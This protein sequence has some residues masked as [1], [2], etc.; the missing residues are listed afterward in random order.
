MSG[1]TRTTCKYCSEE[2]CF[3]H[4]RSDLSKDGKHEPGPQSAEQ[5]DDTDFVVDYYCKLC[6]FSGSV[7]IDPK[8]I[9]WG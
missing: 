3:E 4:C 6:G 7:A 5:A 1:E 9:N 2:D 8:D